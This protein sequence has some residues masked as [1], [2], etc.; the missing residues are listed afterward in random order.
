MSNNLHSDRALEII[1][2][3]GRAVQDS[4]ERVHAARRDA[5]A[6][7]SSEER[8]LEEAVAARREA[9]AAAMSQ[10]ELRVQESIKAAHGRHATRKARI[11]KARQSSR[12]HALDRLEDKEWKKKFEIE[13]E[14]SQIDGTLPEGLASVDTDRDNINLEL[15]ELH[16]KL[17]ALD[18]AIHRG[19]RG[20]SRLADRPIPE[21]TRLPTGTPKELIA[22]ANREIEETYQSLARLGDHVLPAIFRFL[23]LSILAPIVILIYLA[24]IPVFYLVE[25]HPVPYAMLATYLGCS[26]VFILALYYRCTK[27]LTPIAD[28]VVDK[29]HALQ[30]DYNTALARNQARHEHESA[31]IE[32]QHDE[33][34]RQAKQRW[35]SV[36][37]QAGSDRRTVLSLMDE[38]EERVVDSSEQLHKHKLERIEAQH[39]ADVQQ[40][41]DSCEAEV[42]LLTLDFNATRDTHQAECDSSIEAIEAEWDNLAGESFQDIDALNTTADRLFPAWKPELWK[43]WAPLE[44]F[45]SA[46]KF[47]RL[48]VDIQA[49]TGLSDS[50]LPFALPG[51]SKFSV[52]LSLTFP[53][54]GSLLLST[55]ESAS[56]GH[57]VDTLNN[58]IYRLLSTVSP[59]KLSFTIIDPVELGQN[60]AGLMH[61][62]DFEES[63]LNG[64]IW[65][66]PQQIEERLTYL[67][68]HMEKVIQMYLRN[69]YSTIAEYNA[70]AG[71]IAEKYHFLVVADFPSNFSEVAIKRLLS[72]AASGARC[73]VYTLIHW[74]RRQAMPHGCTTDDIRKNSLCLTRK[75]D[76]Y[77]LMDRAIPGTRL[78]L[79]APPDAVF[80]THLL[81]E[82]GQRSAVAGQV[83]VPFEEIAPAEKDYWGISTAEEL[84]VPIGRTGATKLQYFTLGKGTRQHA[85][86]AGKTGSG[87]STLFHVM[88]T[89]LAL[90]CSPDEVEFYLVDFKKGVEFK[91]YAT[92]GLPHAKVIAIESDREFG[93]SVLQRVDAELKRRGDLFR[94]AGVQ[95]LEGYQRS[96]NPVTIPRTLLIIDEFQEFFT[97]DDPI[98]Q[99][100]SLLLDRIVR[101]GRAFGIHLV[102]GSQTLGGAYSLPS[103]TMGQMVVRIALQCNEADAY[104]IMDD[105]NPA[106]RLLSRPG[107]AIY[108][109]AAGRIEGNSPFQ[110]VWFTDAERD[111]YLEKIQQ[112]AEANADTVSTPLV[113]E[114]NA[115]ANVE[116]NTELRELLTSRKPQASSPARIW[117]GAP[118]SIKGPTQVEFRPQSGNN[119][120]IVGQRDEATRSSLALALF[121]LSAHYAEKQVRFIFFDATAPGTTERE[122]FERTVDII[123][124]DI[125]VARNSD[126]PAVMAELGQELAR[127]RDGEPGGDAQEIYLIVHGVQ[128]HRNLR[129]EED[130]SF[131]LDDEESAESPGTTFNTLICEGANVGMHVIA[132]CDTYNNVTRYLSRKALSEFELRVLFQMS[133]GDSASLM[134]SPRAGNLGLHRAIFYNEQEGY[135][136]TFRPYALP[137]DSWIRDAG[138]A[139]KKRS[140]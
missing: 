68:D 38:K 86:V 88:I 20:F 121:S 84:R 43:D 71:D 41:R 18:R 122:F 80:S 136:E 100:A 12:Q 127:R 27:R 139:L 87:K 112:H 16:G 65:T 63:L 19:F 58:I 113:F 67:N 101:Q 21:N 26:L 54:Q 70:R 85:L 17:V 95:D 45:P 36:S 32:H 42:Q 22:D 57:A 53:N 34:L 49:Q 75:G 33:E 81:Q 92:R 37:D 4:S 103:T 107:E 134:D 115:P 66:Q 61:L 102:L 1:D 110:V 10:A 11:R 5:A 108:N 78:N 116:E 29:F 14:M 46:V 118:N 125:I 128:K 114:G 77:E 48:D 126:A 56:D 39:T 117:L 133:A 62:V 28:D 35:S 74:D 72:I 83:E 93:L 90:S 23:P 104:L 105:D 55:R 73:G 135:T 124:H 8:Q 40:T 120:I 131:S 97:E 89:N 7:I 137:C 25:E 3:L 119:L 30:L 129:Y 64:R 109:D 59:N 47:G 9:Q 98:S 24:L 79:D 13:K 111:T 60:F 15:T 140:A 99:N 6:A 82:V 51:S 96:E 91:R 50:E 2:R 69:E 138:K 76:S 94:K 44:G 52:P 31:R 130:Y 106:P 132:T 123:P